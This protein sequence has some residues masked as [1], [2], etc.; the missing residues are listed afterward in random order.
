MNAFICNSPVQLMRAIHMKM[1]YDEF[2]DDADMYIGSSIKNY[3]RISENLRNSALFNRVIDYSIDEL[4]KKGGLAKLIYGTGELGLTIKKQTYH[5]LVSFNEEGVLLEAIYNLNS[6]KKDFV[7]YYVEDAPGFYKLYLP[8]KYSVFSM[9]KWLRLKEPFYNTDS[10]WFSMPDLMSVPIENYRL[11][12]LKKI[13]LDDNEYKETVNYIFDYK[14]TIFDNV[15]I[16]IMEES[17]YTDGRM[18]DN[19][20]YDIYSRIRDDF[21][22]LNIMIKNHP[23]TK[24]NR[25]SKD[26]IIMKESSLPWE[27]YLLNGLKN[28]EFPIQIGIVCCTLQSDKLM[29]DAEGR[30]IALGPMFEDKVKPRIDGTSE[31]NPDALHAFRILRD[32]YTNPNQFKIATGY[33]EIRDS[34]GELTS[35]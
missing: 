5:I 14:E 4:N 19:F 11:K 2:R 32:K 30:K 34:I 27:L 1:R 8:K 29:F 26:F 10:W 9:R 33:T 23:R 18:I 16:I 17:F 20:D 12:E 22:Q 24:V 15:D 31:T 3:E 7:Y 35:R 21:P 13:S 6:K 25:F 28:K